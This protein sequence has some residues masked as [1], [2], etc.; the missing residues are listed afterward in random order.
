MNE[1]E[2]Y[3]IIGR[4]FDW[5]PLYGKLGSGEYEFILNTDDTFAIK[6]TFTINENGE[7]EYKETTF[8]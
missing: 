3:T 2:H 4:K 7:L 5:T 6:I 1:K 8:E